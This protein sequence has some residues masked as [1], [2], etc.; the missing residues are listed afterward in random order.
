MTKKKLVYG[1]GEIVDIV[2]T[3]DKTITVPDGMDL[4]VAIDWMIRRRDEENQHINAIEQFKFFPSE[5][6]VALAKALGR[7]YG[8]S[9][10]KS[11]MGQF[12]PEPPQMIAIDVGV[13]ESIHVP[14]GQSTIPGMGDGHVETGIWNRKGVPSF[15]LT[16]HFRKKHESEFKG[17]CNEVRGIAMKESI[18]KGKAMTVSWDLKGAQSLKDLYPT[19]IN[20]DGSK[21]LIFSEHVSHMINANL[22]APVKLTQAFRR[23]GI[24][25]KSGVLLEGPYG[26]GKTLTA[27]K[28]AATCV[29]YGWTFI[30]VETP[31]YLPQLID[32]AKQYQPAVL[33]CED[34]DRKMGTQRRNEEID[35]ILN[36]VDGVH[37][38]NS[39]V[40]L[41]LTTNHVTTISKAM[42]RP[43][44]IDVIIPVEPPDP[45]AVTRLLRYYGDGLIPEDETL[46]DVGVVLKGSIPATVREVVERAKR[47]ATYLADGE[48]GLVIREDALL[49]AA[50]GMLKHLD[51]LKPEDPEPIHPLVSMGEAINSSI[52]YHADNTS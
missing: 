34:I 2:R 33:F 51:L 9:V 35:K 15:Q 21:E 18:Y 50:E 14:W 10:Q 31:D 43:G 52:K 44:R 23:L 7:R 37:T 25:L 3:A 20:P 36:T 12:G 40:M 48:G 42:L 22:F 8:W 4:D 11:K 47:S 45:E 5:G 13:D 46:E 19:F 26:C 17:L 39:E 6:A 27:Q 38:K 1:V 24:P 30:M 16:G 41:V 32:F 28:L 29:E 49:Y